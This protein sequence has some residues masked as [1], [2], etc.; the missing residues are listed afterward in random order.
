MKKKLLS[1]IDP[2]R[3]VMINWLSLLSL[4][5][6]ELAI[7]CLIDVNDNGES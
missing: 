4:A 6:S 5:P 3:G 2:S 1:T 7:E